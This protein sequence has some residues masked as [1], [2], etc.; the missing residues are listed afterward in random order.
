MKWFVAVIISKNRRNHIC[1]GKV[2]LRS[3]S[4]LRHSSKFPSCVGVDIS[5]INACDMKVANTILLS[6]SL[7]NAERNRTISRSANAVLIIKN[8]V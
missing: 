6:F 2:G 4:L 7:V 3:F 5:T 8:D 1:F